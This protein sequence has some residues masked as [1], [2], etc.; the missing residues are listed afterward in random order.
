MEDPNIPDP[1]RGQGVSTNT[2]RERLT[3][4]RDA[5]RDLRDFVGTI[6]SGAFHALRVTNLMAHRAVK[7]ALVR[8]IASGWN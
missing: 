2:T 5:A 3:D 4:I 8:A 1:R 6:E 7:N